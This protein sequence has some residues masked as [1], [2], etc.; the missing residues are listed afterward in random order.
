MSALFP[1]PIGHS[2]WIKAHPDRWYR[3]TP[4]NKPI[5]WGLVSVEVMQV[6]KDRRAWSMSNIYMRPEISNTDD[7]AKLALEEERP[8]FEALLRQAWGSSRH[9]DKLLTILRGQPLGS[10]Q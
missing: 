5:G 9:I 1:D 6:S 7:G 10:M 2:D 3:I 8:I 4:T